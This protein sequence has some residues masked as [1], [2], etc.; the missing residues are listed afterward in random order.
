MN[1]TEV[2]TMARRGT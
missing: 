2:L 1:V